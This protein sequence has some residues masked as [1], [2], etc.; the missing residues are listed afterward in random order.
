MTVN[1]GDNPNPDDVDKAIG[2]IGLAVEQHV[3]SLISGKVSARD[4][5]IAL[6][7]AYEDK[8]LMRRIT[9]RRTLYG[10]KLSACKDMNDYIDKILSI[11]QQLASVG[12]QVDEEE[13]AMVMLQNLTPE[14]DFLVVALESNDTKL[15]TEIVRAKL[16]Q[17]QE[18]I[19]VETRAED[20]ALITKGTKSKKHKFKCFVCHKI[21][22]KASDCRMKNPSG[23]QKRRDKP[24]ES[25]LN[26]ADKHKKDCWYVDSGATRHFS[27][28]QHWFN[29][30][31]PCVP[32]TVTGVGNKVLTASQVGTITVRL[33][34]GGE[35]VV[36]DI[37]DVL[38]V[39]DLGSNLI[40]ISV[41]EE[42]GYRVQ[43]AKGRCMVHNK[44][45][46]VIASATRCN[47]LYVLDTEECSA[48]AASD[49]DKSMELW[50]KRLG[51][52]GYDN[53][54][55]LIDGMVTGITVSNA[56]RPV[57]ESC[58]KGKQTRNPFPKSASR[59]ETPLALVHTDVCGPMEVESI[60]G[61]RYF[62]TLIDD[63][64]RMTHVYFIKEKSE[65]V[66][67]IVDYKNLVE[68]HK[69]LKLKILRSDNGGEYENRVLAAFLRKH[70]IKHQLTIAYTPEQN[71]VSERANRTIVERARTMLSD[72]GLE[73]RFWA[74]A[75]STAVYLKNRA[76]TVAVKGK[77][78]LEAWSG[79]RPNISHLRVFG[80]KAFA[81]VPKE[82]RRK[83]DP[84]SIQCIMLGYC[85][86]SKGYRLWDVKSKRLLK[87]RDVVFQET[88]PLTE[89]AE[90]EEDVLLDVQAAESVSETETLRVDNQ[91][92]NR[93]SMRS[94]KGVPAKRY[95][96][97]YANIAD[98]EPQNI[99][100]AKSGSDW[101][102]WK[103]A[104]DTELS[105][106]DENGTWTIVDRPSNRKTI[107]NKWVFCKKLNSDGT[108]ARYKA[109]LVAKGYSQ[110]SGIDYGEIYSPVARYS[111]L[112]LVIAIATLNDLLLYQL[113]FD[114]AF[115]NG[116]LVEEIYMEPPEHYDRNTFQTE[117]VCLL[118]KSLYGLKQ[119]GRC[120]YEKLDAVL[121]EMNFVRS[122]TDHCLYH[123]TLEE[124]LF[125]IAVYVDDLL[126]AGQEN[127][128][129]DMKHRL[130]QK[131]KLKDLGPANHLLGMRIVQNLQEGTVTI[132]Q[133]AYIEAIISKYG[134]TDAK[135]VST[136]I[137]KNIKMNKAMSPSSQGEIEEMEDV[138]YQNVTKT[139]KEA[140]WIKET[141]CELGLLYQSETI[142]IALYKGAILSCSTK[143]HGRSKHIA[144]RH[145]FIR[146]LVENKSISVEYIASEKNVADMLTKGLSTHLLIAF[147]KGCGL[148]C[149]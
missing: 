83:L 93:S 18:R 90:Q 64:T 53:V 77:T 137:D 133:Q 108:I 142:N 26:V 1:P 21:G 109:R 52:L 117:K 104:I 44:R 16:L 60:S 59:A 5:W 91:S 121:L 39:P 102:E 20:S 140:M 136:P 101:T 51:H 127:H 65:V 70:G 131:F 8:G 141:L 112:R 110:R 128:I 115:L 144:I 41:L 50:H 100:E 10:T 148:E 40:A 78:P 96:D 14:F 13:V 25:A 37:Q 58:I 4:M 15:T 124:K 48:M 75:V 54:Q 29:S 111:T 31:T 92:G 129:T 72:A 49:Q 146:E 35:T 123:K 120:W 74:E 134:M 95:S 12:S 76:P 114:S 145:H 138:P 113:D 11:A 69:G 2:T 63:A 3:Y 61:Y 17:F 116:E 81:H 132:D 98:C 46:T 6:Q 105:A 135:P 42:K 97:E 143:H 130:Q 34:I 147:L 139:S 22:H 19:P 38:F 89:A 82:K 23:T 88:A 84:K 47:Q 99:Q 68:T 126:M 149:D 9:L 94:N 73:K 43:F 87:S 33:R 107:K 57:C 7:N 66:S 62:M 106:L 103:S 30:L 24:N 119:S 36:T 122:E 125:I 86:E 45:G 27:C 80:S 28:N 85:K 56:E 71:G 79:K 32:T 55:K 118:K 67:K